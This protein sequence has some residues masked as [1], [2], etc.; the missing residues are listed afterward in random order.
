MFT[1]AQNLAIT[2]TELDGVFFPE[3][4]YDSTY[5]SIATAK[6]EA[7]FKP[8]MTTHSAYIHSVNKGVGL[9]SKIGETQTVPL[10]TPRVT[11]KQTVLVNDY[12][13]GIDLSKDFFDDNLFG[14]WSMEVKDM[15]L[16]ARVTQDS[17]AFGLFRGAF[18]TTLTADGVAAISASHVLI[19]GGT[20]SNLVT[21]ALTAT[22]L[23]TAI[24]K[25]R[26]QVD[27]A[28]VVLGNVPTILLVPSALFK[29]AVEITESALLVDSANASN[30]AINV[31][32]SAYGITIYSSPYLDAVS[33]GSDTAWFLLA[34]NHTVSRLI[35]QGIETALTDWTYSK[36]R[37]YFY[38]ANFR[39]S[40]FIT[41]YI[42]LV[43]STG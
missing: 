43:G 24:V 3:Y 36:N 17:E 25:M 21:G 42:G 33:G 27:Q 16:K 38:Q 8:V 18:T 4:E 28:G 41:D 26:Q 5:P 35:R 40:Y 22:T 39:E 1:E 10:A 34:K 31:Y 37:S 23:N 12:A 9:F 19:G 30:N 2:R 29:T 32:R 15:A 6:T 11:N 7:I 20:T 13:Q 14:V